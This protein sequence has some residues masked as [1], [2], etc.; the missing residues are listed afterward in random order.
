MFVMESTR[1]WTLPRLTLCVVVFLFAVSFAASRASA[2]NGEPGVPDPVQPSHE[3]VKSPYT[4]LAE[5][6]AR[7]ATRRFNFIRDH[8]QRL[9]RDADRLLDLAGA[10]K[11]YADQNPDTVLTREM[12][13]QARKMEDLAYDVRKLMFV[14]KVRRITIS[15]ADPGPNGASAAPLLKLQQAAKM[16]LELATDLKEMLD[17]YLEQTNQNTISVKSMQGAGGKEI[18]RKAT[19]LESL[20]YVLDHPSLLDS[21]H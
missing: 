19:S 18:L 3:A 21:S 1:F 8:Y 4:E 20:A 15:K 5:H 11:A 9:R 13:K 6:Q 17:L 2:Q 14:S 10:I 12:L 16:S 7:L